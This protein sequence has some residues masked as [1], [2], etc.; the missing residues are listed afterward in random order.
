[1]SAPLAV[2]AALTLTGL[3]HAQ[4]AHD[5]HDDH[6]DHAPIYRPG[7]GQIVEATSG[8]R[9]FDLPGDEGR[10][11]TQK[12]LSALHPDGRMW[13]QH[14]QTLANPWFEGRAPGTRGDELALD[15]IQWHMDRIGLEPAFTDLDGENP[16]RQNFDF[17]LGRERVV[18]HQSMQSGQV[19][20]IAGEDFN[21]LANSG[22]DDVTAPL[23]FVGYA[24]EEGPDGYTSF[25][26]DTDL[27]GRIAVMMRYEPLTEEGTSRWSDSGFSP[28]SSIRSKMNAVVDRGAVALIMVTPPHLAEGSHALESASTTRGYGRALPIP[29][30]HMT[31]EAADTMLR[32][33]GQPLAR[34]VG[35]ADRGE[36]RCKDLSS[37]LKVNLSTDLATRALHTCNIAGILPGAGDLADDWI[38]IGGHYDH[39]GHGYVGSRAPG[40]HAIHPGADDNASGTAAVLVLAERLHDWAEESEDDRRSI[41]FMGFGGEEAGLHGSRYFVNNPTIDTDRVS[42]MINLDMVGRLRNDTL[43]IGGTG[44]A[45]EFDDMLPGHVEPTGLTVQATR[46]G[47]GPSDHS[48][49]FSGGMPVLFFFTG[50]HDDYHR[51]EDEAWTVDPEGGLRIV[52]LADS[53]IKDIATRDENLTFVNTSASG[54]SPRRTGASVRLGVMPG[55]GADIETGVLV[56][57]VSDNTSAAEGGIKPGD[58]LLAWDDTTLEGGRDLMDALRK[59]KPGDEVKIKINR[60]GTIKTLNVKLKARNE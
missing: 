9:D 58:I 43:M 47:T 16:W 8:I 22:N 48:S 23:T 26:D 21:A 35:Q 53:V 12:V 37:L 32:Q 7:G 54:P 19:A 40:V 11:T 4:H 28:A 20:M 6:A 56:E 31:A 49:F 44:T 17:S 52:E 10:S 36:I 57:T 38:V 50:L 42:A 3:L 34:L 13:Y 2:L 39:I 18:N 1:M 41:I 24:I 15:Y 33:T 25:D 46:G 55:Y 60:D 45:E 29:V 59:H 27:D 30:V 14:V 51:P 5:D